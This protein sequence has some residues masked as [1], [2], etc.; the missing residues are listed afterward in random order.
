MLVKVAKNRPPSHCD[1]LRV[2]SVVRSAV[3]MNIIKNIIEDLHLIANRIR[4]F[5]LKVFTDRV[6]V[7]D[8]KDEQG[9]KHRVTAVRE[10]E[11]VCQHKQI[12]QIYGTFWH[13]MKKGCGFYFEINYKVMLT[14]LDLLGLLDAMSNH[15]RGEPMKYDDD[16]GDEAPKE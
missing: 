4:I 7:V 6:R 11:E 8:V 1:L 14:E 9:K 3:T 13:C 10:E 16:G 15:L 12:E 2:T 5:F